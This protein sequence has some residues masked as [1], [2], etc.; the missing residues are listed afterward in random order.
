MHT[1]GLQM[2]APRPKYHSY[3]ALDNLSWKYLET[4]KFGLERV[5][6]IIYLES[7]HVY[8]V[9]C[10]IKYIQFSSNVSK[11]IINASS[12]SMDEAIQLNLI[13]FC[14]AAEV[15]DMTDDEQSFDDLQEAFHVE[16]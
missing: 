1:F 11:Y 6:G 5:T 8:Q 12:P 3:L 7:I 16:T 4:K 10:Y 13:T 9:L 2:A 14:K 15:S